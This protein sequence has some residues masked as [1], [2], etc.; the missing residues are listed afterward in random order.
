[1]TVCFKKSCMA[2]LFFAALLNIPFT[3][4]GA[5]ANAYS[6]YYY[7]PSVYVPWLIGISILLIC[8]IILLIILIV[9]RDNE[10]KHLHNLIREQTESLEFEST[11]I[12]TIFESIPD[13]IFYKDINMRYIRINKAFEDQFNIKREDILG[14]DDKQAALGPPD[15]LRMWRE[16]D[17]LVFNKQQA[18]SFEELV[19]HHG[20]SLRVFESIKAPIVQNEKVIGLVGLTR[21]ITPRKKA[22]EAM[23]RAAHA[24][25]IFIANMSHEIRTPMNSILGFSEL[26]L[27]GTDQKTKVYLERI[28]ENVKW[29]LQ[30]VDDILDI[31][32]IESDKMELKNVPFDL[33][34]IINECQTVVLQKALE[35]GLKLT[36][37][38]DSVEEGKLIVGDPLRLRQVLINLLSNAIKFTSAGTIRLTSLI[39]EKTENSVC[40]YFE[41]RD[42]GIG[43]TKEQTGRIF[44]SFMQADSNITRKY[45]GTGL[46]LPITKNLIELM[47]GTLNVTSMQGVG[48]KF[49]FE[50][51][52]ETIEKPEHSADGLI[53]GQD[54]TDIEKPHFKGD[55]LVCEDNVMNRMV[56]DEHLT[57][58]GLNVVMAENGKIGIEK[59]KERLNSGQEAFD[60]IF[61]DI[62][63]PEMDGITATQ[64][65]NALNT[66][67]PIVAMTANIMTTDKEKYGRSGMV[68]CV[69]KPFTSQELWACILKYLEPIERGAD[70]ERTR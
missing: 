48:S 57:R 64:R 55:V 3:V 49:S 69:G 60:L 54:K 41:I 18:I 14:K 36:F 24:K 7:D 42:S 62:Q 11:L 52:Y 8:V 17:I 37:Y 5:A 67:T 15:V 9:K 28:I 65:I 59:V 22:E 19:P 10:K 27:T 70:S 61:M 32:K 34:N 6:P 58:V 43:M 44:E 29:L 66:G 1:M 16:H 47:G 30:I 50:I 51:N 56:I 25:N 40:I 35:K 12:S 63:M 4:Y 38:A 31:S 68:D 39:K 33:G 26:A 23:E 46:G 45:G 53:A 21:D 2:V 20:G 13:I